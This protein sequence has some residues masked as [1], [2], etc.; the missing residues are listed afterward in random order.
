[1]AQD[2][3][4]VYD[5]EN[6]SDDEL[7][8]LVRESI[9]AHNGLDAD[10]ITVQVE[11]GTVVLS[12]R[13]GTD[14]ERRI[15]EHVV[16][17]VIGITSVRNEIFVDA[18]RRAESPMPIDDHLAEEDRTEGLLL[19]DRPSQHSD[20]AYPVDGSDE[21]RLEGSTDIGHVIAHGVPWIPPEGPTP[22]GI[23]GS[24]AV[25]RGEEH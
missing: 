15:A 9:A 22:E 14:G 6:L 23:E 19:G 24:D 5:L 17:D 3:E 12:G 11:A 13:V 7:R 16:T 2:F 18:I 8:G 20:E 4:N 10:D 21:E 1:M 25:D